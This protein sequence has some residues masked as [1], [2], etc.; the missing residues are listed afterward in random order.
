MAHKLTSKSLLRNIIE[1]I[2]HAGP[3]ELL[4]FRSE[5]SDKKTA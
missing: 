2:S 5:K 3:L 1:I 4:F